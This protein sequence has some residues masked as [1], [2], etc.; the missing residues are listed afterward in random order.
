MTWYQNVR[1][2]YEVAREK[3]QLWWLPYLE[4]GYIQIP[5]TITLFDGLAS[6]LADKSTRDSGQWIKL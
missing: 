6:T 1:K 4:G 2:R 5:D 3:P